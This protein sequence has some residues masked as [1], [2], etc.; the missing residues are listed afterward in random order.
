LRDGQDRFFRPKAYEEL[1]DLNNDPDKMTNLVGQEQ[2]R[3][4]LRQLRRILDRQMLHTRDNGFVP[5]GSPTEGYKAGSV[6]IPAAVNHDASSGS[7]TGRSEEVRFFASR[8]D[9]K[10]G[11]IRYWAATGLLIAAPKAGDH[12]E[13]LLA[14][15]RSDAWPQVRVVAAEALC[16]AGQV[17]Q[18]LPLL[19][20]IAT[21]TALQFP[22]RLQSLNALEELGQVA[23]PLLPALRPLVTDPNQYLSRAAGSMVAKLTGTY[24]PERSV[25]PPRQ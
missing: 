19:G 23:L 6:L 1:Y 25:T 14:T 9:S 7:R 24:A 12:L 20:A 11:V 16:R 3:A 21:D 5:E 2:H 8:L 17:E 10:N 18:G 22:P 13:A 15:A 4:V